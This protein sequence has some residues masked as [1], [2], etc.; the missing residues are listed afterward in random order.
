MEKT[1][2]VVVP[3]KDIDPPGEAQRNLIDPS[4]IIELAE[5]IREKGLIQ[6]VL[7]RPLNGRFEIVAGHRR[8]LAHQFLKL[9]GIQSIVKEMGD[10]DVIIYRAIENL[11]REN[12]TPM[13]EAKSYFLMKTH[14][15]MDLEE[16]CKST[17]KHFNTVKR[18]LRIY[19]WPPEFQ[20]AIDKRGVAISVAEE[21]LK[22]D[23][24]QMR[25]Y[26]L[27]LAIENGITAKVAELWVSEYQKSR[28]GKLF[29]DVGGDGGSSFVSPEKPVFVTCQCCYAPVEIRKAKQLIV[30]DPCHQKARHS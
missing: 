1:K 27:E 30:C 28:Q 23:D 25:H 10:T 8:F 15:G 18:F 3:L 16:I 20:D 14:G 11:Q 7:L 17:G 4:K 12:L 9:Q 22:V 29:E 13:E 6:P 24:P 5:S 19:E 21:L 26:Y 2:V